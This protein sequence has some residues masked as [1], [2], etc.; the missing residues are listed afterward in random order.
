MYAVEIA[1]LWLDRELEES[2]EITADHLNKACGILSEE[3][4]D[5]EL[6]EFK[7]P[8][9]RTVPLLS[10]MHP[11][12]L[13]KPYDIKIQDCT[14]DIKSISPLPPPSGHHKNLN[15]KQSEIKGE[16]RCDL[17]IATKCYPE[18]QREPRP[19]KQ[20]YKV[21]KPWV[22]QIMRRINKV[23]FLGYAT[24]AEIMKKENFRPQGDP[25]FY[26]LSP[27]FHSMLEFARKFNIPLEKP[28]PT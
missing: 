26:S 1:K 24:P 22:M 8:H 10:K 28:M 17:Y 23:E 2:G 15:V 19:K 16:G 3:I 7:M 11:V 6:N 12:N 27:P 14:I 13:G 21:T 5:A 4:F 20:D 25:P 18:L 9:V